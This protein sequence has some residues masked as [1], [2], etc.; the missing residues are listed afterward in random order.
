MI[1]MIVA[2]V[3]G[4]FAGWMLKAIVFAERGGASGAAAFGIAIFAWLVAGL[5]FAAF[6]ELGLVIESVQLRNTLAGQVGLGFALGTFFGVRRTVK[7]E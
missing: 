5:G 2:L 6:A 1:Y 3:I 4:F 7:A